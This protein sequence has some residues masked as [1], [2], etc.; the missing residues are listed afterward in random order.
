VRTAALAAPNVIGYIDTLG[1]PA[2]RGAW[3]TSTA[4]AVGDRVSY[5]G[6]IYVCTKAHTSHTN[7][8]TG[9]PGGTAIAYH[10][11]SWKLDSWL[12]GTGKDAAATGDGMRD[13]YLSSDGVH[14]TA[15]FSASLGGYR[16]WALRVAESVAKLL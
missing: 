11:G 6:G 16:H 4:Y 3:A 8:G 1:G 13:R 5:A 7:V 14:P 10:S 9:Y 12:S 15:P 2:N